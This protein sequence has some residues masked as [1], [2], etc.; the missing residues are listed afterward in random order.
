[1]LGKRLIWQPLLPYL[2][3][4]LIALLAAMLYGSGAL[5]DFYHERTAAALEDRA[6]LLGPQITELLDSGTPQQIDAACKELG[7]LSKTRITVILPS[8]KVV[9]DSQ[10]TLDGMENHKGRAEIADAL[11]G[12]T[13]MSIHESSTLGPEMMYVA[14]PLKSN[15]KTVG[16]LRTSV[17]VTDIDRELSAI[18][19]KTLLG[20]SVVAVLAVAV[21]LL[22]SR[23]ISQPLEQLKRVR[24]DFVANVSHEL[25]TPITSIKGFVETLLD[26]AMH[27]PEDAERFL[28]IVA[29]QSDRL[30]EIIEDLLTLSRL[31]QDTD[32]AGLS[33]QP[34]RIRGVLEAAVGVCEL[35]ASAKNVSIELTCAAELRTEINPA[36]LEQAVVNL[37]DNAV[38][39]S[40]EQ[41]TVRVEAVGGSSEVV[42]RVADHGCG[43]G[44]EH[45]PRLFERF[46]RVDKA[47]SRKLGGTG[48]GLA[49]VKHI[50]QAHG[51]RATVESVPDE[52][53]T[54][55][56]HLP[57]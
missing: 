36:L 45:L 37:V 14:V 30:N 44:P 25:K 20:G 19:W 27:E 54:F 22:I 17:A 23:R 50:A 6:R 40:P 24:S 26:G 2:L 56:L 43:I 1:M 52:G 5:R 33:L 55:S 9:G 49:I 10:A 53:S 46:Y 35:K 12:H 15:G 42:I 7:R 11:A 13:G 32:R 41:E 39:Y 48:L 8:G 16:A 34:A 38:K 28:R 29:A 57:I 51:G 18:R 3:G 21:G 47:R 4:A 31:E